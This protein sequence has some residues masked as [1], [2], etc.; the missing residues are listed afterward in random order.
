[1]VTILQDD[2]I[3]RSTPRISVNKLAE[4]ITSR[5]IRQRQ[6][7]RDQKFPQDFK[8]TY[9]K[10]A[11]EAVSQCIAS[12]FENIL[13][14]ERA[15][16]ILEQRSPDRIGT[17]RRIA[18][19]ADAI[20]IFSGM[21]DDIDLRGGIP[22][23]GEQFPSRMTIQGVEISV[24]PEIILRGQARDGHALLGAMKVHFPRTFPLNSDSAGV[25]SAILQRYTRDC[26]VQNEEEP[27]APY[28]SVVDV[29]SRRFYEGV[30]ATINR[31]REVE[32]ECRNI[33]A[34]WS[35]IDSDE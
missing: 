26:L 12:N 8:V 21:L 13:S 19:N 22:E 33:V 3:M 18:K 16:S 34:I 14:L 7:L 10:E 35:S 27:F 9:Y 17:A 5:G 28:C 20:E 4:Y 11:E 2:E 25:I 23:L 1:L 15:L 24:R 30:R 31:M 32:A 6:I 29:G